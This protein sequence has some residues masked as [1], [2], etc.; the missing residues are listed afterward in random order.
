MPNQVDLYDNAYARL[1]D[2]LYRQIRTETYGHDLGQTSWVTS[3]ESH[4]I[5]RLL[6]LTPTSALLELGCGSGLYALHLARTTGCRITGID[7]NPHAIATAT[8]LADTAGLGELARFQQCDA[9]QTLPFPDAHFDAAFANDALCHIPGRPALLRELLRILKPSARLLF[10][11]ALLIG[12]IVSNLELATRSSIGLY[13]FSPAGENERLLASAGFALLSATDTS[14]QAADIAERWHNARER[15]REPLL[16]LEGEDRYEGLQR[17][18]ANVHHLTA[19]RR[20]L[21]HL[22]LAEKPPAH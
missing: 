15:R 5:P 18:L 11:D 2:D 14:P 22:Y 8:Q 1:E 19:E 13:F 21:R 9:S 4:S 17:F 6:N 7:I 16:A 20:L 10:S 12:G 3:E